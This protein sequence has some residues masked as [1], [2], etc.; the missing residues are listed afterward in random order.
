MF[1]DYPTHLLRHTAKNTNG[2]VQANV[3]T[4]TAQ[5]TNGTVPLPVSI[6]VLLNFLNQGNLP[7]IHSTVGALQLY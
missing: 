5:S 1:N 3:Y 2:T 7:K 6:T 4:P